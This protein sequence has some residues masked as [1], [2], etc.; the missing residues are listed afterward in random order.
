MKIALVSPYDFAHPGGVVNHI[1]ALDAEFTALGHD[2]RIIAP[3]SRNRIVELGERFIPIGRPR[4][5]PASGSILRISLSL[6]LAPEIKDVLA[7]EKFDVVHLHEPFMPMLCS[8]ILR[9]SDSLNVGTFH[10]YRGSPGYSLG[11]PITTIMLRRRNRNLDGRIA[12]SEPARAYAAKHV[13]GEFSIIPNGVDLARFNPGVKAIP[14]YDDGKLNIIFVGRLEM[15]KGV[16]YLL[17]AYAR[18]KKKHSNIRL[19]V[20]GPGKNLRKRYEFKVNR[21]KLQDVIF[22][23]GVPWDDLPR[24]YQAG[25]IFCAPAVGKESFGIVLLE[26]MAMGKPI[27]ATA[28]DGY[29]SVVRNGEQALLVP[30]KNIQAL[31]DALE[32]LIESPALRSKLGAAGLTSVV[33]YDWRIVARRVLDYYT[34][35]ARR[36][37]QQKGDLDL[38]GT[39]SGR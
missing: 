23:G 29:A 30:P 34:Y 8:A 3:A 20:V 17:E 2:V 37:E 21:M 18:L 7:R 33:D 14:G 9:F 28:I 26:A 36:A 12:V 32:K 35:S 10:A 6:N 19:I 15:R 4:S 31:A 22:T 1:M 5:V 25:D 13:A 39:R 27:V 16:K 38:A 11:R 24:Y